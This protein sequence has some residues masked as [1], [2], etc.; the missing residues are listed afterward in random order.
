MILHDPLP[1]SVSHKMDNID[2]KVAIIKINFKENYISFIY[3]IIQFL[4]YF[5]TKTLN[6]VN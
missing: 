5:L 6:E 4:Q 2:N 1:R 3:H